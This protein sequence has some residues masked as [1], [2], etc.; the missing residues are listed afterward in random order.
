MTAYRIYTI[1][2]GGRFIRATDVECPNDEVAIEAAQQLAH[3]YSVQLWER[4]R[5]IT[6]I[7]GIEPAASP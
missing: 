5:F 1:G 4:H 3:G 7:D 6:R 2:E